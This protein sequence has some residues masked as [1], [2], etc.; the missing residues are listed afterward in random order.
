MIKF[1]TTYSE[2]LID[3]REFEL[4]QSGNEAVEELA[5]RG[6]YVSAGLRRTD[7]MDFTEI[8]GTDSIREYCPNDIT[9][10]RFL[11][12]ESAQEWLKKSRGPVQLRSIG[13]GVLAGYGWTGPEHSNMVPEGDTTFALRLSPDFAGN[14]LGLPLT[15]IILAGSTALYGKRNIWLETWKSNR[16]AVATYKHAGAVERGS[17]DGRR[18][19]L[20]PTEADIGG[21]RE[22]TRLYMLF[23]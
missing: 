13:S 20:H 1:P 8:A 14:G 17:K 16:A 18:P 19:T 2:N 23:S 15:Q 6:F 22:D 5:R 4:S 9:S 11:D 10:S 21:M 3:I 12:Q 7:V